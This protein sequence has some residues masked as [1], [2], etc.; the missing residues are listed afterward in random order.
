V[1]GHG[2]AVAAGGGAGEDGG[3]S[4]GL[5]RLRHGS[6]AELQV[7]LDRG[8]RQAEAASQVFG[9]GEQGHR[10]PGAEGGGEVIEGARLG[11]HLGGHRAPGRRD[12]VRQGLGRRVAV[13]REEDSPG[14]HRIGQ[15]ARKRF[16]RMERAHRRSRLPQRTEHRG[17]QA[18]GG[19][20]SHRRLRATRQSGRRLPQDRVRDRDQKEVLAG[21]GEIG[22]L[23]PA[24]HRDP[25]RACRLQPRTQARPHP[26]GAGQREGEPGKGQG[27]SGHGIYIH[28]SSGNSNSSL[29]SHLS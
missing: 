29:L 27:R 13:H 17:I 23:R 19:V 28:E 1:L 25:F 2:G 20:Q 6:P 8:L 3:R 15:R 26:A 16:E 14:L 11:W 12:P 10:S 7:T 24:G 21:G 4:T 18:P 22:N 9:Q 5:D